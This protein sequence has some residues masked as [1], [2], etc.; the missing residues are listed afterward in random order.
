MRRVALAVKT[1]FEA[2]FVALYLIVI[3]ETLSGVAQ[4]VGLLLPLVVHFVNIPLTILT[5]RI[6]ENIVSRKAA[7]APKL[8]KQPRDFELQRN[9]IEELLMKNPVRRL[10][11]SG[12]KG[13]LRITPKD[14]RVEP[15]E[16]K[17]Y[18]W[19]QHQN[20]RD[21]VISFSS[22]EP[23]VKALEYPYG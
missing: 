23:K 2:V 15:I 22:R 16:I 6:S 11:L 1:P 14:H 13:Y 17:I 4:L 3:F 5:R 10:N 7:D 20:L 9:E 18:G 12:S 19:K 21:L 8:L